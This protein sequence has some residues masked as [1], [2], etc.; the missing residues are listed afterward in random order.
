MPLNTTQLQQQY[1]VLAFQ[2]P[3]VSVVRKSDNQQGTLEFWSN[4]EGDR[5][6]GDFY[7]D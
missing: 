1:D 5:V 2:A 4:D 7:A 3:F 6:Y